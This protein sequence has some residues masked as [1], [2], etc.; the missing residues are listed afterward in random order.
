ML[1]LTLLAAYYRKLPSG[2]WNVEVRDRSGKK[3]YF[4]DPLKG[5]TRAW[6]VE[7]EARFARGDRR[8]PRA[9]DIKVGEWRRRRTAARRLEAP[10]AAKLDSLW[11]THYEPEWSEWPMAAVTRM[12]AQEWVTRICSARR[13]RHRGRD[14]GSG[15][16]D[17]P[18]LSAETVCAAVHLMSS[19]Y[20]A[21]MNESPPLVPANPF[22]R[23]ELPKIEPQPVAFYEHGEAAALYAATGTLAGPKWCTPVELGMQAGLRPGE[24]FGL[25][26][27]RVDWLR[28]RIEVIDVMTRAGLRQWPKSKWSHRVVPVPGD[29]LEG[30]S[31]LMTGRPR[32]AIVFTA[33]E[34]GSVSDGNFRDR[35]WYPA[36]EAART[37]GRL[38]PAESDDYREGEC[39]PNFC[40]DPQAPDPQVPAQGHAAHGSLLAG[41]GRRPALRR[42]GAP[43]ARELRHDAAV[44]PP[45]TRCPQPRA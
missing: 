32:D 39:G 35:E 36:V 17:V 42:S 40:D 6:A 9:G 21:A 28:A 11:R 41:A 5:V 33:P 2:H 27:H 23:L 15:D 19:L 24:L 25:R 44:R 30:M 37:C 20:T 18:Q 29:I 43:R 45:C 38:A 34:G 1:W 3:H 26:G 16:D 13:A 4:T 14:V 8:D 31:V 7:H 22:A 10:T 12:E